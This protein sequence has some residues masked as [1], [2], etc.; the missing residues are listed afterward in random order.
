MTS[1]HI[2]ISRANQLQLEGKFH[3]AIELY[4]SS[5]KL[6]PT[7]DAYVNLAWSYSSIGKYENAI[8]ECMNAISL[9]VDYWPAY[10]DIGTNLYYLDRIGEAIFWFE[11]GLDITPESHRYIGYFNL[12]R[13]Y[14]R[15]FAWTEALKHYME[16]VNNNPEYE[17]AKKGVAN[18]S[19]FLN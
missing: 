7:P 9:N 18:M 13:S 8:T 4:K 12:G 17:L 6:S 11:K 16:S 19:A 3:D 5:I 2:L 1:A 14:E 15:R 10:N